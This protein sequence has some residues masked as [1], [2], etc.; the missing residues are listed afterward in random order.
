MYGAFWCPHCNTQKEQ[1]G[2]AIDAIPY[3]ECD[4]EGEN[5]QPETC[6]AKNIQGY[7]TWEINGQLSPGVKSLGELAELSG[8]TGEIPETAYEIQ[9]N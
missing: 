5:A 1:F 3:I 8:F 7:P 2:A 4:P 6:Q 9:R